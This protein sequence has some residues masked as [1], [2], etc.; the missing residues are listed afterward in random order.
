[1]IASAE[2]HSADPV[3]QHHLGRTRRPARRPSA[4]ATEPSTAGSIE[5]VRADRAGDR[6]HRDRR[7]GP[8]QPVPGPG[9]REGEVGHPV[10]PHVRLGVDAVGAADPQR[11][12]VLQGRGRAAPRPARPPWP[13]ARRWPR[14]AAPPA[15]CPA[16]R[17]RSCR[18]GRTRP[19]PAASVLS[20]HAVRKAMT[21]C[22]VTSS[23]SATAAGVGGGAS[24]TGSTTSAGTVPGGRVRLQHQRLH[25]APQL[26]LVRVAPDPRPS[27]AACS[28]RSCGYRLT[29]LSSSH[30]GTSSRRAS[31]IIDGPYG[32]RRYAMRAARSDLGTR[33]RRIRAAVE[34]TRTP[35][36]AAGRRPRR[37]GHDDD[38]DAAPI[39]RARGRRRRSADR[40]AGSPEPGAPDLDGARGPGR[41]QRDRRGAPARRG[42]ADAAAGD[43]LA[44]RGRA[45][46]AACGSPRPGP[47]G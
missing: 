18:S 1:M 26:V 43:P 17:T 41:P 19:P 9:R 13:A 16:G 6:R 2:T 31:A 37:P 22:W 11:V 46:R 30:H 21:S 42:R 29:Q 34:Q 7:P 14:P 5:R 47:G 28:A 23:I 10:A 38:A 32:R 3:A 15:R 20:A 4:A 44:P 36:T 40:T 39:R 35:G 33:P 25:P 45:S 27:R 12:P 8:A 24:R